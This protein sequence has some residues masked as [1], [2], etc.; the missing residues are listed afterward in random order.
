MLWVVP[1]PFAKGEKLMVSRCLTMPELQRIRRHFLSFYKTHTFKDTSHIPS[2]FL[3]FVSNSMLWKWM[4]PF[5]NIFTV[6]STVYKYNYFQHR[7]FWKQYL[8]LERSSLELKKGL[9]N[10]SSDH[11]KIGTSFRSL[12][13]CFFLLIS[14]C[15]KSSCILLSFMTSKVNFSY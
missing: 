11:K 13:K 3:Q 14:R 1:K 6:L 8:K 2:V 10:D 9:T 5:L 7:F 4:L 12:S 15:M